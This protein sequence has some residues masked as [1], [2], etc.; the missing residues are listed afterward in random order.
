[1]KISKNFA[2]G[3]ILEIKTT[4]ILLIHEEYIIFH[5]DVDYKSSEKFKEEENVLLL[6][7]TREINVKCKLEFNEEMTLSDFLFWF[8]EDNFLKTF[9][10]NVDEP[11]VKDGFLV[12][13]AFSSV[14]DLPIIIPKTYLKIQMSGTP[15]NQVVIKQIDGFSESDIVNFEIE[16]ASY[17]SQTSYNMSKMFDN[18]DSTYLYLNELPNETEHSLIFEFIE[19]FSLP[20]SID[21][22]FFNATS[23]R[24]PNVTILK[25]NSEFEEFE[26]L[27]EKSTT[28]GEVKETYFVEPIPR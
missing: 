4:D 12:F 20:E 28:V 15:S 19:N 17:I 22:T 10:V 3:L 18:I 7:S 25:K 13:N 23:Y 5:L 9:K 27:S 14:L 21:I 2:S 11:L 24:P 26:I 6:E 8:K 16:N 1:M